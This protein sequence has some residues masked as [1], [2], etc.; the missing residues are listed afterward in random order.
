MWQHTTAPVP[1]DEQGGGWG[2][3][4]SALL[5]RLCTSSADLSQRLWLFV[6]TRCASL[7]H[8]TA[9]NSHA[10]WAQLAESCRL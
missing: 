2:P 1:L 9:S 8:L 3:E 4:Q 7:A 10:D 5:I 6:S